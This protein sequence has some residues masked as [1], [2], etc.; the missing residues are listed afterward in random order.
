MEKY[1]TRTFPFCAKNKQFG[2]N[3]LGLNVFVLLSF[4]GFKFLGVRKREQ[5]EEIKK[6]KQA[7]I[8]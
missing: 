3:C 4:S 2:G 6:K 5:E 7:F 8:V 1:I